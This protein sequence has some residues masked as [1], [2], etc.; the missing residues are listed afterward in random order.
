VAS[1]SQRSPEL[2]PETEPP[3]IVVTN[4]LAIV[5]L[6]IELNGTAVGLYCATPEPPPGEAKADTKYDMPLKVNAAEVYVPSRVSPFIQLRDEHRRTGN[7][8]RIV[9]EENQQLGAIWRSGKC[10]DQP[11]SGIPRNVEIA[12]IE[13]T[14]S[15]SSTEILMLLGESIRPAG[16]GAVNCVALTKEVASGAPF[17]ITVEPELNPEPFTVSVKPGPPASAELGLMLVI[18]GA[19]GGAEPTC[20]ATL[21][22]LASPSG[23]Y[24]PS[25]ELAS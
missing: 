8:K 9:V 18:D 7:R 4:R 2:N 23:L 25:T 22:T 5:P 19:E 10:Y 17:H 12:G 15:A 3:K 24:P 21:E 1:Y 13:P 16:T 14:R 6:L 11:I 20:Q